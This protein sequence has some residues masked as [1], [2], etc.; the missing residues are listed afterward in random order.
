M[1]PKP[2]LFGGTMGTREWPY[3]F[4]VGLVRENIAA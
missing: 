2:W 3:L 1:L 4:I